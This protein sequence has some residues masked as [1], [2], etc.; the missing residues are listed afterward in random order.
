MSGVE[1]PHEKPKWEVAPM[2]SI[3]GMEAADV[4]LQ[5]VTKPHMIHIALKTLRVCLVHGTEWDR[6]GQDTLVPCLV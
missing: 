2:R 5:T 4:S 3:S 6:T 1:K